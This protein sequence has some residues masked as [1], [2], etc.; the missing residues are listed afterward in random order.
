[1]QLGRPEILNRIG[2][3]FVVFDFIREDSALQI[4]NKHI[5]TI[6]NNIKDTKDITL[7]FSDEAVAY[8]KEK[9]F[10]NLENGG[11][12][13]GNVIEKYLINPLARYLFDNQIK[14][15]AVVKINNIVEENKVVSL[16]CE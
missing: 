7:E 1:M 6:S 5:R 15:G 4:L 8:L 11:R 16:V 3:N 2:E 10:G 9:S 12:G 14:A 13:I